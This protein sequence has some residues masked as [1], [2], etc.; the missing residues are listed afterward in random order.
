[1]NRTRLDAVSVLTVYLVVLLAVPARL[2]FAPL[3]GAGCPAQILGL[4][5]ALW[6][7][8]QRALSRGPSDLARQPVRIAMLAFLGTVLLSYIAAALRPIDPVELR[9]ADRGLLIVLSWLGVCFLAMD[10]ATSKARLDVLLRRVTMG[11]GLLATLGIVQ[12]FSHQELVDKIQIPG[13]SSN[14]GIGSLMSTQGLSR[15]AGTALHPIEFGVVLT[16]ILPLALHYAFEKPTGGLV[17]RWFPVGAIAFA[18]PISISRSAI[19]GALIGLV[20]LLP[21]WPVARR[22]LAY[23]WF[24]LLGAVVYVTIPGMIGT[25]RNLFFGISED[26]SA[27]SRTGSY[28]LASEFI[29]RSPVIGRGF[30]TFLPAYRILDNQYLGIMIE[31]GLLG[32][33]VVLILF[34]S[35]LF[36]ARAAR[37][38][39]SDA[40]T[41]QLGQA[42]AA[43]IAA[44]ALSF[45]FFDAFSFPMVSGLMF[46]SLGLA[47][48]LRSVA[49]E[50]ELGRNQLLRPSARNPAA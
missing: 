33:V 13:L 27:K 43:S 29:A 11:G 44:G 19:L 17:R 7:V 49:V 16:M 50:D 41:R 38:A 46:L 35:G 28:A 6:W 31:L 3:G 30:S 2:V 47:T 39:S 24:A 34:M 8:V 42:L 23:L 4:L 18:V 32:L 15:P 22:R 12:F 1:M 45:A 40:T 10:G 14:G 21:T 9:A 5:M 48:A 26:S 20:V 36:T 25:F 37:R